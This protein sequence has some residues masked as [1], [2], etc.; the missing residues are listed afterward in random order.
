MMY[1][2]PS[3]TG[4]DLYTF[5]KEVLPA[6]QCKRN[7]GIPIPKA[8]CTNPPKVCCQSKSINSSQILLSGSFPR[9]IDLSKQLTKTIFFKETI[10]EPHT[11]TT[12]AAFSPSNQKKKMRLNTC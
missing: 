10:L 6:I 5:N 12:L 8:R 2:L 3:A 9:A 7:N 4:L 11:L 1:G